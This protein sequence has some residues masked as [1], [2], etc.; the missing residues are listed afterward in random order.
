MKWNVFESKFQMTQM[1][2]NTK[3]MNLIGPYQ[4]M[5]HTNVDD[6]LRAFRD[7]VVTTNTPEWVQWE[8]DKSQLHNIEYYGRYQHLADLLAGMLYEIF[9]DGQYTDS[10]EI[11]TTHLKMKA[12]KIAQRFQE[13]LPGTPSLKL[14]FDATD[15]LARII[16]PI[17]RHFGKTARIT[18]EKPKWTLKN[19]WVCKCIESIF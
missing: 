13:D 3:P 2:H 6:I 8:Q 7:R 14:S 17:L 9:N 10:P 19:T 5:I 11:E 12:L 16:Y 4:Q 18:Q 1:S 15:F